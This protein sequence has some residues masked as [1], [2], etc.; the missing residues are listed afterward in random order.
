MALKHANENRTLLS[1]DVAL[2][3]QLELTENQDLILYRRTRCKK[4]VN[5]TD[6][7]TKYGLH[8]GHEEVTD[9]VY[10]KYMEV[11]IGLMEDGLQVEESVKLY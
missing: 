2:F 5:V 10:Q 4:V 8:G 11:F 6:K 3:P 1:R 9:S 7:L